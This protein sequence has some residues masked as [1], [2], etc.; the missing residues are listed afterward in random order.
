MGARALGTEVKRAALIATLL[1]GLTAA[2]AALALA[3]GGCRV[4]SIPLA[5]LPVVTAGLLAPGFV[6]PP[7]G[8]YQLEHILRAP[9]GAVLD[10]DGSAHR[11]REFTTGK[12]TLFSFIYTYCTDARGCPLAYAALHALKE[13]V[14]R[15]A[16]LR[17]RVRLVSMSFDPAFDT[18]VMMRS[19]GGADAISTA[20]L[21]WYFLTTASQG[22]LAPVLRGFGQDVTV[23]SPRAP[24]TRAPVAGHLLK[25]YLIDAT[26]TVREIYS[27]AYLHPAVLHNDILTL[28][29]ERRPGAVRG[30]PS[31]GAGPMPIASAPPVS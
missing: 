4:A 23:A 25:V 14:E 29:R 22:E 27:T 15:D 21:P 10:S 24:G 30:T 26:G 16:R 6:P 11:L 9:D 19:Y 1:I 12:I 20:A 7:A 3:W 13:Q 2:V 28:L 8:S 18:P 31:P 17:G 5:P